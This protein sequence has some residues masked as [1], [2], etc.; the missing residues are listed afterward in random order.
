MSCWIKKEKYIE[1]LREEGRYAE[2]KIKGRYAQLI[3][4]ECTGLDSCRGE[5]LPIYKKNS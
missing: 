5:H 4:Q 2:L 1:E 3:G